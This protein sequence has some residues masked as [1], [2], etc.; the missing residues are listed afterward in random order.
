MKDSNSSDFLE[1]SFLSDSSIE[2]KVK[3]IEMP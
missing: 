1:S 2:K 3:N